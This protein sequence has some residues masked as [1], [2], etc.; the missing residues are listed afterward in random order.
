MPLDHQDARL[1]F[2]PETQVLAASG[3]CV[4]LRDRWFAVDPERGLIFYDADAVFRRRKAR[5][6]GASPACNASEA[7]MRKLANDLYPWAAIK[8]FPLVLQPVSL[9]DYVS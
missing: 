3:M 9:S 2:M 7:I 6:S 5:I 8:Q 4:A 1:A